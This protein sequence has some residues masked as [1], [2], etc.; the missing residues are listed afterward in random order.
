MSAR[1]KASAARC[2]HCDMRKSGQRAS[3]TLENCFKTKTIV[4]KALWVTMAL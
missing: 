1:W 3:Q 4:H 2:V